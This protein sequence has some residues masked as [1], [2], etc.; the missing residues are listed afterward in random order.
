MPEFFL[1]LVNKLKPPLLDFNYLINFPIIPNPSLGRT[2][3]SR[4]GTFI[5]FDK[6]CV[7]CGKCCVRIKKCVFII[8]KIKCVNSGRICDKVNFITKLHTFY[9]TLTDIYQNTHN[10]LL[11]H[12]NIINFDGTVQQRT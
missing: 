10:I 9:N 3:G 11:E 12:T 1:F 7:I 6:I 2:L 5:D 8:V 4:H